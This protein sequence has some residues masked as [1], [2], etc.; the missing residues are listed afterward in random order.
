MN[1]A[2]DRWNALEFESAAAA[3][4]P[5]N[6]SPH[7]ARAMALS[8]PIP[9]PEALYATSDSIWAELPREAWH[10]AFASHPRIGQSHA[11]ATAQS[12]AWSAGEQAKANPD[13]ATRQALAEANV[14]YEEKFGRIFIVCATGKSAS[15]ML[16]ILNRRLGNDAETEFLEAAE[17]QRQITRIRLKKWLDQEA[18]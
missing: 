1:P 5:C 6:G 13:E 10:A 11:Q 7:W 18:A 17:Q 3:I 4:L 2:L 9:M 12:L 8:R 16:E 14:V 15:E